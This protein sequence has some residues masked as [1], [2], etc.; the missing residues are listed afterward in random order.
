MAKGTKGKGFDSATDVLDECCVHAHYL[1]MESGEAPGW[2]RE[3]FGEGEHIR[4]QSGFASEPL[5]VLALALD[6][7]LARPP[8]PD[9]KIMRRKLDAEVKRQEK[10]RA[11]LLALR[12]LPIQALQPSCV[13]PV[14][15]SDGT[16]EFTVADPLE[17][18]LRTQGELFELLRA[19]DLPKGKGGRRVSLWR[20]AVRRLVEF[21]ERD[22]PSL[23]R[24]R[25]EDLCHDLFD[26]V[27]ERH[28][29]QSRSPDADPEEMPRYSDLLD[30]VEEE[31]RIGSG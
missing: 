6:L 22:N 29:H 14:A 10:A 9:L 20:C 26:K 5:L 7:A 24:A 17:D 21:I 19:I 11:G 2:F 8:A 28:G 3:H 16:I 4:E 31:R 18:A 15:R 25:R 27:R 23:T 13:E 12:K 1:L 30:A